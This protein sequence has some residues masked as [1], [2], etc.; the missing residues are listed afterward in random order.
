MLT[1][2]KGSKLNP[3]KVQVMA[4]EFRAYC[5]YYD[6]D[7]KR[8]VPLYAIEN[9]V[10]FSIK[11]G[12]TSVMTLGNG[13]IVGKG[14]DQIAPSFWRGK[15]VHTMIKENEI[16]FTSGKAYEPKRN[17]DIWK[18]SVDKVSQGNWLKARKVGKLT[19]GP[20]DTK[21]GWATKSHDQLFAFNEKIYYYSGNS[22]HKFIELM[23]AEGS[24]EEI[25]AYETKI[26]IRARGKFIDMGNVLLE[27]M[28]PKSETP[29]VR[30]IDGDST[31]HKDVS[32]HE[33]AENKI[34]YF[35]PVQD[36]LL[37]TVKCD[38]YPYGR[39]S[40]WSDY[41]QAWCKEDCHRRKRL[42]RTCTSVLGNRKCLNSK[43]RFQLNMYSYLIG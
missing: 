34:A 35:S 30:I 10:P 31:E 5:E 26:P 28:I 6:P 4:G 12:T 42:R 19:D 23:F 8:L 9:E 29:R 17:G 14:R 36:A 43:K 33:K 1:H 7:S 40:T 24:P 38:A 20:D 2:K 16:I 15:A 21:I 22:N 27:W 41:S 39:W 32:I 18:I 25:F 11:Q 13:E 37:K 3:N